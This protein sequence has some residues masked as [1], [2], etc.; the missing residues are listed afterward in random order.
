MKNKIILVNY[1][2]HKTE[3]RLRTKMLGIHNAI[4]NY[5][6]CI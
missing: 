3:R 4:K 6:N 1:T 5:R 2:E